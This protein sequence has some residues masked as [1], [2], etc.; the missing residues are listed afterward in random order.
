[1]ARTAIVGLFAVVLAIGVWFLWPRGESASPA[2]TTVLA[3]Q[4]T[5]T[6]ASDITT[7]TIL[8]STTETASESHVVETVEEAE[9]ILREL[10]FGWFEGIYNQDEDRIREVVATE[11]FLSAGIEAFDTLE[12]TSPP[13][14]EAIRF[15]EAN[16]LL[17]TDKCIAIWSISDTSFLA[18]GP[19]REGLEILR[20]VH[21]KWRLLSSWAEREDLWEQDCE[22]QLDLSF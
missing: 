5:T 2:A 11:E 15:L 6:R 8:T 14:P 20:R 17:A 10:W 7:S 1:M 3:V 18:A 16:L 19:P 22:A 4:P 13:T 21:D 12:F 9:E